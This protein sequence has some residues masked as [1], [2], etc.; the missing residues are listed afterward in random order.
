MPTHHLVPISSTTGVIEWHIYVL[1]TRVGIADVVADGGYRLRGTPIVALSVNALAERVLPLIGELSRLKA[2]EH[3]TILG[4]SVY[5]DR[6]G[7]AYWSVFTS[8]KN[9]DGVALT[10]EQSIALILLD[11]QLRRMTPAQRAAYD[12]DEYAA[13]LP[14]TAETYVRL[15]QQTVDAYE[16]LR[17]EDPASPY[18]DEVAADLDQLNALLDAYANL[19]VLADVAREAAAKEAA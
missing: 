10:I 14:Y 4:C 19:A 6:V 2:D 8:D 7:R 3:A 15:R 1:T 9:R 13:T 17:R 16:R 11:S 12:R 5:R 18:M